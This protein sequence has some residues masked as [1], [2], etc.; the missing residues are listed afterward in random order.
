[1]IVKRWK[2]TTAC[3]DTAVELVDFIEK[4]YV[5]CNESSLSAIYS[6]VSELITNVMQHAYPEN[7]KPFP[8]YEC[9]IVLVRESDAFIS[10]TV[11]DRGVTIPQSVLN[12]LSGEEGSNKDSDLIGQAVLSSDQSGRGKGLS[13]IVGLVSQNIFESLKI[14]SRSGVFTCSYQGGKEFAD[15]SVITIGTSI[16][17]TVDIGGVAQKN[18]RKGH[19]EISVAQDFSKVP[20][21][22]YFCDGSFSGQAFAKQIL[23]PNLDK[24]DVVTIVLDGTYGYGSSFLEEAFG[25]L[26]RS[27][28]YT[29]SELEGRLNLVSNKN[30]HLPHEIWSYIRGAK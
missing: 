28:G 24:Y 21:G 8:E 3:F 12:K 18:R 20:A 5:D 27:K 22:R 26:V 13:T 17:L 19:I 14:T 7:L 9:E 10:V 11:I 4:R 16:E 25:G 23:S 15:S 30:L 29:A 6:S 1:M 2:D